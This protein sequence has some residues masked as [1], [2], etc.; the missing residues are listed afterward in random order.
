MEIELRERQGKPHRAAAIEAREDLDTLLR[1][2]LEFGKSST[3][4][5]VVYW[6]GFAALGYHASIDVRLWVVQLRR[7][8]SQR[9]IVPSGPFKQGPRKAAGSCIGN[10]Q[11][12]F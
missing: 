7:S 1:E 9:M 12:T 2:F 3:H 4:E 6:L 8:I 10:S 5:D 11:G